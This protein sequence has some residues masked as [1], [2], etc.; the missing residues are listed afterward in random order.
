MVWRRLIR[1][2]FQQQS[3]YAWASVISSLV[4]TIYAFLYLA[5]WQAVTPPEG[6]PPYTRATIGEMVVITQVL[7]A[8]ALFLPAGLGVHNL[9]RTGA[10]AVE[11]ARPLSFYRATLSRSA[12]QLLHLALYRCLPIAIVLGLS[13]GL[14]LPASGPRLVGALLSLGL[15]IYSALTIYYMMGLSALWT[16]QIRWI[17]WLYMSVSQFL[18]GGWIP[19]EVLPSWL[20]PIAFYS[21]MAATMG[22][23]IR[24]YQGIGGM[25]ALLLPLGWATLLTFLARQMTRS[26]LRQV[27]IQG[28]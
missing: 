22:H 5:L 17:H 28:G 16:G 12:G 15:G 14:P 4:G 10:I 2:G 13:V 1:I 19:F 11:L 7:A 3:S 26:A 8:V 6:A 20:R 9:V 21:P 18:S 24:L 23:A 25:E 27:E